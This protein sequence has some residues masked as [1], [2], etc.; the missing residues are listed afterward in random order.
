MY[1]FNMAIAVFINETRS[2]TSAEGVA[3]VAS[4]VASLTQSIVL[5]HPDIS[6]LAQANLEQQTVIDMLRTS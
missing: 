3:N 2:V 5:K 1:R 6:E 4:A